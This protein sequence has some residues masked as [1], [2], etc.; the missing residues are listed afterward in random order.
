MMKTI[1]AVRRTQLISTYGVGA[2]V[3]AEDASYMVKGLNDW[4]VAPDPTLHEPRLERKLQVDGFYDPP[5]IGKGH[6]IPAVRF[7]TWYSC[8]ECKR[9]AKH[10]EF[11]DVHE[12]KCTK[13]NSAL[14]PSRFIIACKAGHIDDFPFSFWL[15][16]NSAGPREHVLKLETRGKSGG[17]EDLEISCSCGKA[18]RTLRGAFAKGALKGFQCSGRRPWLSD[19]ERGCDHE[20]RTLQRGASNVWFP[21]TDSSIS[22][23]P[24]S[25][26]AY[27]F[28]N[29]HWGSVQHVVP[30]FAL[31]LMLEAMLA[32]NGLQVDIKELIGLIQLRKAG[33][34]TT[35]IDDLRREEYDALLRGKKEASRDDQFVCNPAE[36]PEEFSTWIS[37]VRRVERLREVRALVGFTRLYP[38]DD[39]EKPTEAPLFARDPRWR[40]AIEVRGEGVFFHLNK[41]A[42]ELWE[43]KEIV[44]ARASTLRGNFAGGA[45]QGGADGTQITPRLLLLHTLAHMLLNQWAL[46]SGYPASSLRE[47]IYS[48]DKMAGF[49]IYT[50]SSDSAGSLGGVVAQAQVARLKASL[51]GAL[52]RG[53]WCSADPLCIEA[54]SQGTNN[55]NLAACHACVL[56]PEVSCEQMNC[57]LDRAMVVG[58]PENPD[59][60]YFSGLEE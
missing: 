10:G 31:K 38:L 25:E 11:G 52:R 33:A 26:A 6:D 2:L 40:P 41:N 42:L 44:R 15:H 47:R 19:L 45:M 50:A 5:S 21:I 39:K 9:L 49:L 37:S 20:P 8:P 13:C 29:R 18:P 58:T 17:L 22:I 1:A 27:E 55:V 32:K 28:V 54:D 59:M 56:L 14:V 46:D 3:A 43:D 53:R 7:P 24:W 30:E 34:T 51:L 4:K 12:N 16:G 57:F 60:G 35:G 36:V 48:S 23:P